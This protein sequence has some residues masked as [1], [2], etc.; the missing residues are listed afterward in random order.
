MSKLEAVASMTVRK[1]QLEG[2]KRQAAEVIRQAKEKDTKT[3]RYDWFL[4]DDQTRC[5]VHEIY[6]SSEGLIEHVMHIR[7]AR[8]QL[9]AKFAD[10]HAIKI[11]GKPS[12]ELLAMVNAHAHDGVKVQWYSFLNGLESSPVA[13]HAKANQLSGARLR[14]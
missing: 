2:F 4:S 13:E 14:R 1:G 9:F 12:A 7:E 3:L 8:D 6:A 10:D 11:Y 5:E